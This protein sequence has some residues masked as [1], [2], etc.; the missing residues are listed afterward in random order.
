[1]RLWKK[2]SAMVAMVATCI[3]LGVPAT[4][5]AETM[6]R[7]GGC[8]EHDWISKTRDEVISTTQHIHQYVIVAPNGKQTI[9]LVDCEIQTIAEIEYQACKNCGISVTIGRTG[10]RTEHVTLQ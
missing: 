2:L 3:T 1:M 6:E 8:A 10:E 9:L 7:V 5:S 4:A